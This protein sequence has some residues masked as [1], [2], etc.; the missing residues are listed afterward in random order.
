MRNLSGI[1]RARRRARAA[2]GAALLDRLVPGWWRRIRLRS[3]NLNDCE[4]CITGQL[5]GDYTQG[6]DELHVS[7]LDAPVYGFETHDDDGADYGMA[8]L[9]TAWKDEIRRRKEGDRVGRAS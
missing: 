7:R 9:T 8:V 3:L 5:F 4:H 2:A 1:A 6:L